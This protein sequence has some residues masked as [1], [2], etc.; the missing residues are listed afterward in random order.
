MDYY[1][2]HSYV[3]AL[4]CMDHK[5]QPVDNQPCQIDPQV[6]DFLDMSGS[7][8]VGDDLVGTGAFVQEVCCNSSQ[9]PVAS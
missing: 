9:H 3:V 6:P 2:P 1:I 7:T 8:V 5:M 4:S